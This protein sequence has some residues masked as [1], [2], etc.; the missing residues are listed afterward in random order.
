M[1]ASGADNGTSWTD[2]YVSLQTAIDN[3]ASGDQI[4]V[5]EGIYTPGV[6]S[7]DTFTLT[8]GV[9]IY[10]G[11]A[12]GEGLLSERDFEAHETVLSGDL[13]GAVFSYHVV[14][15][16]SSSTGAVLDGFTVRAGNASGGSTEDQKG[17]GIYNT[18]T[19]RLANLLVTANSAALG[20]GGMYNDTAS[21][22]L[23][24]VTFFD[25]DTNGSGGAIYN[26][27]SNP[28]I[29]SASF[30]ANSASNGGA[31][32]NDFSSPE[33]VSAM[34]RANTATNGGAIYNTNSSAMN[35]VNAS[36]SGNSAGT[37]GGIFNTGFSNPNVRN[38]ILW[39]NFASEGPQIRVN[40][41]S[42]GLQQSLIEGGC[43]PLVG[44]TGTTLTLDPLFVDPDGTDNIPG[45]LDDNLRLQFSSPAIDAGNNNLVP[46]DAQDIDQDGNTSERIPF[47]RDQRERFIE[48]IFASDTGVG[49]PPF[50]DLGAFEARV[51]HVKS[52][53]S[54]PEDGK[55]WSS[56]YHSLSK[57]LRYAAVGD[58]LWVAQGVYTPT[59]PGD[60][61]TISDTFKIQEGLALYGGFAGSEVSRSLR[62]PVVY[63]SILSGDLAGDDVGFSNNLENSMNVVRLINVDESTV[64]D[65]FT[66]QGGNARF[67]PSP[68]SHRNY[69]KLLALLVEEAYAP[70]DSPTYRYSGGGMYL[71]QASPRL[72]N[73]TFFQNY[74]SQG[75]GVYNKLGTPYF[76]NCAWVGNQALLG[77]GLWNINSSPQ[78][79]NAL[80]NGNLSEGQGG[81]M[82][83]ISSS[84]T[85][86]NATFSQN[87]GD[88]RNEVDPDGDA[89]LNT[90]PPAGV[91]SNPIFKNSLFWDNDSQPFRFDEGTTATLEYSLSEVGCPGGAT[92]SN[93]LN[94]DPLF[95][96]PDGLDNLPGTL[97]D[98]LR[99]KYVSPAVNSGNNSLVPSD[100][101]DLN[102]NGNTSEP[103]PY[104]LLLSSRFKGMQPP[105]VVDMGALESQPYGLFLPI[106][107]RN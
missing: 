62:N 43:P 59:Y 40:S 31:V 14:T 82:F 70:Q 37:G 28:K 94:A 99:L 55:S 42:F 10:G 13:G 44:C 25:N 61:P 76:L 21:P 8:A 77:G 100:L 49:T 5:A 75:G 27:S 1:D 79:V 96:D 16:S 65:G 39:G 41:G 3:A 69:E 90:R 30:L 74:A 84:P 45:T 53:L 2:A 51:V 54:G 92:C 88:T 89:I 35:L 38:S 23:V 52:G 66:I 105:L 17:G 93:L 9:E 20:G 18:G 86:I 95:Q 7:S 6:T 56:A 15:G 19:P 48:I 34:F 104:D 106:T 57:A 22:V 68:F 24:N 47:D 46:L 26:E 50:V 67:Y 64:L 71:E 72:A 11:F 81:A 103:L 36:L 78:I 83:N 63:K 85:V 73:L 60:S 12:G 58:E 97:D 101:W 87:N 29:Y 91:M 98:D 32:Y 4:W 80:F 107:I 102:G 33:I